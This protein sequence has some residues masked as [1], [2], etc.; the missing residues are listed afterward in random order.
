MKVNCRIYNEKYNINKNVCLERPNSFFESLFPNIWTINHETYILR[1]NFI[2]YGISLFSCCNKL[3]EEVFCNGS[4]Y[5]EKKILKPAEQL[6]KQIFLKKETTSKTKILN[7]VFIFNKT[8]N[9]SNKFFHFLTD[10]LLKIQMLDKKLSTTVLLSSDFNKNFLKILISV[11]EKK[12]FT[13]I[14][15]EKNVKYLC[16]NSFLLSSPV[17]LYGHIS[18]HQLNFLK[19]LFNKLLPKKYKKVYLARKPNIDPVSKNTQRIIL[20]EDL[21][22]EFLK[23]NGFKFIYPD[24]LTI[25]EC[26][27]YVRGA[28]IIISVHGSQ[29]ANIIFAKEGT[30]IIEILPENYYSKS[31]VC[32]RAISNILNL[33]YKY[34]NG[35]TPE[36]YFYKV[37]RFKNGREILSSNMFITEAKLNLIYKDLLQNQEQDIKQVAK[38]KTLQKVS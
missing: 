36:K 22:N 17:D 5:F 15:A 38:S 7:S 11:I 12:G 2:A 37:P 30:R 35:L 24:E 31:L 18:I 8:N 23:K 10:A 13:V 6:S 4:R 28:N 27:S 3:E 25:E 33:N 32:Y 9:W 16:S 26:S 20:N 29:L 14:L 21:L 19:K 1:N 34:I